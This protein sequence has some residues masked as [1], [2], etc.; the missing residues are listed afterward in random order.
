MGNIKEINIKN[1]TYYFFDDMINIEDF[2]Y[3][4]IKT[5]NPLYLIISEVDGHIEEKNR[6][7]YLV[8]DSA[9]LRST[10][11]NKEALKSIQNSG[12]VLKMRLRQ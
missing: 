9:D 5:V 4:K 8:F 2:D 7:K 11:E 10:D 1:W 6:S 3:V 12:M